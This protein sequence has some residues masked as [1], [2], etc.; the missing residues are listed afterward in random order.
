MLTQKALFDQCI[1]GGYFEFPDPMPSTKL[2]GFKQE[3]G[4]IWKHVR[5]VSHSGIGRVYVSRIE[6]S[7]MNSRRMRVDVGS[8]VA[9]YSWE[10]IW[11]L[12]E[13]GEVVT[14][15]SKE[16]VYRR[17]YVFWGEKIS[18]T[19]MRRVRGFVNE[20]ATIEDTLCNLGEKANSVQF[21]LSYFERTAT[22]IIYKA[23]KGA[24]VPEWVRQQIDVER[25]TIQ[26]A[27]AKID[28]E[29]TTS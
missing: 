20:E 7:I 17:K 2:E 16:T 29:A 11:L 25:A 3:F 21:V 1:H 14:C 19:K 27:C 22:A 23:P 8:L 5:S 4:W 24:S 18:R 6:P 26:A 12:D 10:Y 15:D 13:N 28:A 9:V